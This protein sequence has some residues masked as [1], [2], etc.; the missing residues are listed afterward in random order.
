M[1]KLQKTFSFI[2]LLTITL[3]GF[4]WL[5]R[6]DLPLNAKNAAL[7]QS[8]DAYT[9]QVQTADD[10]GVY[11]NGERILIWKV[12]TKKGQKYIQIPAKS[13][14]STEFRTVPLNAKRQQVFKKV[15]ALAING[16]ALNFSLSTKK[17]TF[18]GFWATMTFE[19]CGNKL[20]EMLLNL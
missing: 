6:Q 14:K 19:Q 17:Y 16:D 12:F 2:V 20:T 11:L 9:I 13:G 3:M 18:G 1:K 15:F 8:L 4:G 10:K 7:I 5:S